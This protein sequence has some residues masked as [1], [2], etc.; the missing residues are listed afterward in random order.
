M[1]VGVPAGERHRGAITGPSRPL[2]PRARP[3]LSPRGPDPPA[4]S[5]GLDPRASRS[6]R[7]VAVTSAT[8]ASKAASVRDDGARIPLTFRT[9]WRAAASTASVVRAGPSRRS[10]TM[11]RHMALR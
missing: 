8:A 3:A 9:Y 11:L 2:T 6:R 5:A 7:V 1:G 4:H 10:G